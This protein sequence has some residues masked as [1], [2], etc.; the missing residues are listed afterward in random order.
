MCVWV[1]FECQLSVGCFDF[2]N[3]GCLRYS[4]NTVEVFRHCDSG[5]LCAQPQ[6]FLECPLS[7]TP[8]SAHKMVTGDDDLGN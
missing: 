5:I 3:R 6:F 1:K 8:T 7:S 2:F 4:Q